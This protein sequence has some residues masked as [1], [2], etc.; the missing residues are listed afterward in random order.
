MRRKAPHEQSIFTKVQCPRRLLLDPGIGSRVH[1]SGMNERP[2]GLRSG[3]LARAGGVS[4]DTLR[5]YE[6]QGVLTEAPR[7]QSGYRVY[8]AD[9]LDRVNMIRH[10]LRLGFTLPELAQILRTRD[11]DGAPC[12]RVLGM[13]EGKLDSLEEQIADLERLRKYMKR[14]VSDWRLRLG[15]VDPGTRAH[16]LQSMMAVPAHEATNGT[17]QRRRR[18][19]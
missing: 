6:R 14:L 2:R 12:K 8:P 17:L 5:H 16:L 7:T 9:S 11:R 10:A 18:Q 15:Q 4:A 1:T 13:L 3:E 19:Q